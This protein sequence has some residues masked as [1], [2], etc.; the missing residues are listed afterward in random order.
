MF[1]GMD[2]VH[3]GYLFTECQKSYIPSDYLEDVLYTN[4]QDTV[5]RFWNEF[6]NQMG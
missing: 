6:R 1:L 5:D 2:P 4:A 3:F